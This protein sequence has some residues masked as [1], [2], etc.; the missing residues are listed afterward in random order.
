MSELHVHID[1][2]VLDGLACDAAGVEVMRQAVERTLADLAG[3]EPGRGGDTAP[4]GPGR[5]SATPESSGPARLGCE[6]A[7]A[8]HRAVNR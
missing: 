5:G 4:V 8:I 3:G 6:A 2:L 1:R 7:R